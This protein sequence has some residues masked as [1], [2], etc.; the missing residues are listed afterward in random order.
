MGTVLATDKSRRLSDST[1]NY[2]SESDIYDDLWIQCIEKSCMFVWC[3]ATIGTAGKISDTQHTIRKLADIINQNGQIVHTFNEINSCREFIT[4]ANNVCLIVS[5]SMGE[6]LV[7]LI[8]N[9]EQIHSI[10]VFCYDKARH[11]LWAKHYQKVR[12]VCTDI[13]AICESLKSYIVS[14][15][16]ADYNQIEFDLIHHEINSDKNDLCLIYSKLI[17]IILLNMDSSDHGKQDMINYCRNEY[18]SEYQ[19]QLINEFERNYSQH[20]PIWWYTKNCF[21]QGIVNRALRTHDLY[22]LCSMHRFLKDMDLKLRQL[23]D[24]QGTSTEPLDLYFGQILLK[25]D[26]ERLKTNHD[27]LMCI[28][29]FISASPEQGIAMMFIKQENSST[30]NGNHIRVV[31]QI[32]I[33]RTV[34][35]NISYANIGSISQFVHEK[36]YLISMFSM[37]RINKIEKLAEMPSAYFVQLTLIGRNDIQYRNLTESIQEEQLNNELNLT[38]L[39]HMIKNRLH[40][41]KSTNKLFKK[42]LFKQKQELRTIILHYNMAIIYDGLGEYEKSINEYHNVINM[43]RD[44]IPSCNQKDDVCLVPIY[45]NMGLT[46]QQEKNKFS[47]ALG[48]AFRALG[49]VSNMEMNPGLKRE[50]ESSCCYCLGSIHD[51]EGKFTD[52]KIF[53]EQALRI[54]QAY[55]PLGHPDLTILQRLITLLSS[56]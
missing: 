10:Y 52:A 5:G 37:Y 44:L 53:Y 36:E 27:G 48:N 20:N 47:Y 54:R 21:F 34:Q 22:V 9:L 29:Q 18:T 55:L 50:L 4:Y 8:H 49:I 2:T 30:S 17:Q 12:G 28:N 39:G 40:I 6:E 15:S 33:D 25:S 32:H 7:P 35:S 24:S 13:T 14:R 42:L 23:H 26:F 3:D 11:E 56:E 1:N 31:F 45:A 38:E 43:A 16:L 19:I 46:Y 51:Q 41:F